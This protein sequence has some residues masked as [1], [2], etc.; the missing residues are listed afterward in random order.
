MQGRKTQNPELHRTGMT[1]IA[2]PHRILGSI[3]NCHLELKKTWNSMTKFTFFKFWNFV[4]CLKGC[5]QNQNTD[6]ESR[7][8]LGDTAK[9]KTK[10]RLGINWIKIQMWGLFFSQH[11]GN[12]CT[13]LQAPRYRDLNPW[14]CLLENISL[15]II[16]THD[17]GWSVK[18]KICILELATTAY[19]LFNGKDLDVGGYREVRCILRCV[20]VWWLLALDDSIK[21]QKSEQY[22]KRCEWRKTKRN[23]PRGTEAWLWK[24]LRVVQDCSSFRPCLLQEQKSFH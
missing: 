17:K 11:R 12:E 14:E 20:K 10:I 16:L 1:N 15:E 22:I 24:W 2:N 23:N 6:R 4:V 8:D 5:F 21:D 19:Q 13:A 3:E 7:M 9:G 18:C